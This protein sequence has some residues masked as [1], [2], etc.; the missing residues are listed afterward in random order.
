MRLAITAA[1]PADRDVRDDVL[2]LRLVDRHAQPPDGEVDV[3]DPSPGAEHR[4]RCAILRS[5]S[6]RG[7]SRNASSAGRMVSV[8][9]VVM[10]TLRLMTRICGEAPDRQVT[11]A[12]AK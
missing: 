10:G 12:T 3:D 4:P 1:A 5:G 8:A 6:T 11:G 9:I 7:A 2:P